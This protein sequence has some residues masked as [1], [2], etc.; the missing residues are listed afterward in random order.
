MI[1]DATDGR[2]SYFFGG[3]LNIFLILIVIASV[4]YSAWMEIRQRRQDRA[5]HAKEARA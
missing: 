5:D 4:V 1:A 2:F 3:T